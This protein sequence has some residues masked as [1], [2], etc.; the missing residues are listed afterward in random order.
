MIMMM[1]M[2]I[3]KL[4]HS[5]HLLTFLEISV[6]QTSRSHLRLYITNLNISLTIAF[7]FLLVGCSWLPRSYTLRFL[8]PPGSQNA[9]MLRHTCNLW[10]GKRGKSDVPNR[11]LKD[12]GPQVFKTHKPRNVSRNYEW[13][14]SQ[15]KMVN[16]RNNRLRNIEKLDV[17]WKI[18]WERLPFSALTHF[19]KFAGSN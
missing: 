15:G 8:P 17:L 6:P 18:N 11:I 3:L 9:R 10:L 2:M 4:R 16:F 12:T 14:G 7:K 19:L 5:H 13:M 1:M